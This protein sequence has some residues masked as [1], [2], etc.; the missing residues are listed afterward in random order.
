M[1][2]ILEGPISVL[3]LSRQISL[4]LQG[5]ILVVG[6]FPEGFKKAWSLEWACGRSETLN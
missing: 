5:M 3:F 2:T 4:V 6:L 1:C